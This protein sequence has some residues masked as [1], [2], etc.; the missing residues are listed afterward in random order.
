MM[1]GSHIMLTIL[2]VIFGLAVSAGTFAFLLVIGVVPR[3]VGKSNTASHAIFYENAIILGG[4][5]GNLLSVFPDIRIWLG[6]PLLIVYGLC[7]GIFVGCIAV[8]LAEILNTFPIMFRRAN[9]KM[10]LSFVMTCM[11]FGKACGAF[12]YFWNHMGEG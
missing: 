3:M 12:F 9:L 4:T 7:A 8:A 6:S 10:G 5:I 11:A 1:L 2:G